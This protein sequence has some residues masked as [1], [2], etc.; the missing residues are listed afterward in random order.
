MLHR[1]IRNLAVTSITAVA[2][3]VFAALN[4]TGASATTPVA[5][6][7]HATVAATTAAAAASSIEG[8]YLFNLEGAYEGENACLFA[9]AHNYYIQ[10][11]N[12]PS[13]CTQWWSFINRE[14]VTNLSGQTDTA[15]EIQLADTGQC[16]NDVDTT[17]Y[18]D[19][20]QPGD[21]FELFWQTP[22]ATGSSLFTYANVDWSLIFEAYAYMSAPDNIIG[23]VGDETSPDPAALGQ[24][25]RSCAVNC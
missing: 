5:N 4:A 18:L 19:S 23:N 12:S 1:K 2:A 24:W 11:E 10:T 16:I 8:F 17:E 6:S 25:Y 14:N 22:V 9:H 21:E 7:G 20:C 3:I 15:W 13:G